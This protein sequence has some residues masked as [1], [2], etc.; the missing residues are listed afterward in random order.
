MTNNNPKEQNSFSNGDVK[1]WIEQEAIHLKTL[2]PHGDPV[3]LSTHEARRLGQL[4]LRLADQ[5]DG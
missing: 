5:V 4:L 1:L 3:E 2:D